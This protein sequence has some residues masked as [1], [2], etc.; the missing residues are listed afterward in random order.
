MLLLSAN[1]CLGCARYSELWQTCERDF[2]ILFP[3]KLLF[4]TTTLAM[5]LLAM[6]AAL[7]A[8]VSEM[9]PIVLRYCATMLKLLGLLNSIGVQP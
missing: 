5:L 4:T 7:Q 1:L 9:F 8:L 2:R 6:F 3:I